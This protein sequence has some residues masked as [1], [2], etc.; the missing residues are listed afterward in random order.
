[1]SGTDGYVP[2]PHEALNA[3]EVSDWHCV[4]DLFKRGHALRWQPF[5]VT[6]RSLADRWKVSN[7]KVWAILEDLS[8]LGWLTLERGDR[9]TQT[10]ITVVSPIESHRPQHQEA[11]ET[12]DVKESAAR[13]SDLRHGP[14]HSPQHQMEGK[15]NVISISAA[16]V[17]AQGAAL[18][19]ELRERAEREGSSPT[20]PPGEAA[21]SK[22]SKKG[23]KPKAPTGRNSRS[24]A[25][26]NGNLRKFSDVWNACWK[27]GGRGD[28]YPFLIPGAD[29]YL[30]RSTAAA[31]GFEDDSQAPASEMLRV[32]EYAANAYLAAAKAGDHFPPKDPPAFKHFAR[33]IAKWVQVSASPTGRAAGRALEQTELQSVRARVRTVYDKHGADKTRQQ[34]HESTRMSLEEKAEALRFLDSLD[35][36]RVAK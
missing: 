5:R 22:A 17:P 8:T 6:E 18:Q 30:L 34:I 13:N 28:R 26:V 19:L 16:Q 31:C 33:D 32:F 14:Q 20:P 7:R 36:Q 12:P 27:A 4:V 24:G 10:R 29:A 35:Q 2:V 23:G 11:V 3:F 25:G 21:S 15:S 1:M 9:H